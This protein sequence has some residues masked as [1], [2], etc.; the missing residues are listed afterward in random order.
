MEKLL[1]IVTHIQTHFIINS[2]ANPP[3]WFWCYLEQIQSKKL[4]LVDLPVDYQVNIHAR[5]IEGK[6]RRD[7]TPVGRK[8]SRTSFKELR[9]EE[10]QADTTGAVKGKYAA[11]TVLFLET[12]YGS[13]HFE[14][15]LKLLMM[16][17]P[18]GVT[19]VQ[20]LLTQ[21]DPNL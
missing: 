8:W 5:Q 19:L 3:P 21:S 11:L 2:A 10:W 20:Q 6:D 16:S 17:G 13:S 12:N 7:G 18:R 4:T 15:E 14:S 1:I 9:S